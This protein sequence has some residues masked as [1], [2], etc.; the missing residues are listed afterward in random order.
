MKRYLW[1]FLVPL[2]LLM[3]C[4]TSSDR[5]EAP[6]K[7]IQPTLVTL[8]VPE[9]KALDDEDDQW[10]MLPE[11][12]SANSDDNDGVPENARQPAPTTAHN[13]RQVDAG[14]QSSTATPAAE[15]DTLTFNE[16]AARTGLSVEERFPAEDEA[17]FSPV[18][19]IA[20]LNAKATAYEMAE[21]PDQAASLRQRIAEMP[22]PRYQA[23]A[24]RPMLSNDNDAASQAA[25]R[26]MVSAVAHVRRVC[27]QSQAAAC[28]LNV[29]CPAMRSCDDEQVLVAAVVSNHG[30]YDLQQVEVT[31][32]F[33]GVDGRPIY[34]QRVQ[35]QRQGEP[36]R[37]A[38]GQRLQVT[39]DDYRLVDNDLRGWTTAVRAEVTGLRFE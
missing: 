11:A 32:H 19:L 1:V 23:V 29:S 38:S 26:S 4:D 14:Q 35:P 25:Y 13:D 36:L 10:A 5:Q 18:A 39:E 8:D 34:S 28:P 6:Q 3:G 20:F 16:R 30:P 37:L 12:T 15:D 9:V 7:E 33:I 31:V 27:G 2:L 22:V 24:V 17:L 21:Q